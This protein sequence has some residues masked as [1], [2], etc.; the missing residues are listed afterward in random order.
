M[1]S[2]IRAIQHPTVPEIDRLAGDATVTA[3]GRGAVAV[4]AEFWSYTAGRARLPDLPGRAPARRRDPAWPR[5]PSPGA[6]AVYTAATRFIAVGMLANQAI[7]QVIQ[8]RLAAMLARGEHALVGEVL[9][10]TTVWLVALVWPGYL[11]L[12]VLAPTFMSVFGPGYEDGRADPGHPRRRDA[13]RQRRRATRRRPAHGRS[14]RGLAPSTCRWPSPSTS[15]A[16]C[17][18]SRRSASPARRSR[19]RPPSSSAT[20]S[21]SRRPTACSS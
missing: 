14:K 20:S 21:P 15:S 12:A 5:W 1:R 7:Q 19:G 6:A 3:R 11:A 10:R 8:P 4:R 17:C 16:A 2:T 9:R 13:A 18:C